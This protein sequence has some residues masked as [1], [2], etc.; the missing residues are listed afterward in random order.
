MIKKYNQFIREFIENSNSII[1]VKMQELND[2]IGSI[3]DE[4]SQNLIYEW[5]NKKEHELIVNFTKDDLSIR[6]EF[7]I[8]NL[9]IVKFAGDSID[10]E[11]PVQSIDE[12]LDIIEKDIH[13]ILNISENENTKSYQRM[14]GKK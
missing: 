4:N 8:D 3:S 1:D 13:L 9:Y 10:F 2:L 5:E 6:Y 7:D 12:G 14:F 11:Q